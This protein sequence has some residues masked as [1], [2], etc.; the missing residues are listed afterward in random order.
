MSN[1]LSRREKMTEIFFCSEKLNHM[2][3]VFFYPCKALLK[4]LLKAEKRRIIGE[5]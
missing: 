2:G 4:S 1:I 3:L 5:Q